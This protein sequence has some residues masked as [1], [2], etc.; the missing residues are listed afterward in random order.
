MD[1][2]KPIVL[3][4]KPYVKTNIKRINTFNHSYWPIG[5]SSFFEKTRA[6]NENKIPMYE[7]SFGK[8][9]AFGGPLRTP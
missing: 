5:S 2:K 7:I 1:K 6:K 8:V 9:L 4:I 3:I